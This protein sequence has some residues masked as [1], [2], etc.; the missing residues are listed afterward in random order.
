MAITVGGNGLLTSTIRHI[1]GTLANDY[2]SDFAYDFRD[3]RTTTTEWIVYGTTAVI[4]FNTL[5][6]NDG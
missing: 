1:D 3:R 2:S 6:N 4:T 5:D